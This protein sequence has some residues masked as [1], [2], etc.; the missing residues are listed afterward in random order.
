MLLLSLV[1]VEVDSCYMEIPEVLDATLR[2]PD[3]VRNETVKTNE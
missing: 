2:P 3:D 1:A